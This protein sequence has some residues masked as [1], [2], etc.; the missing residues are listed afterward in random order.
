MK[1]PDYDWLT[2][3]SDEKNYVFL[4]FGN[5][6]GVH[7]DL[8]Y[9]TGENAEFSTHIY[10]GEKTISN[11]ASIDK[12]SYSILISRFENDHK[13]FVKSLLRDC[14][15]KWSDNGIVKQECCLPF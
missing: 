12:Y 14:S 3:L 4:I 11:Y 7:G 5:P 8:Y 10:T 13:N 9:T 15:D 1:F 6:C 2:S